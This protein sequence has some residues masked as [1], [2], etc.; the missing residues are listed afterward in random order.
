MN[1]PP[2]SLKFQSKSKAAYIVATA[3]I[4]LF[5]LIQIF[6][7]VFIAPYFASLYQDTFGGRSLPGLTNL[8][9]EH[10]WIFV[11]ISIF[12]IVIAFF[13]MRYRGSALY[14][15]VIL[16]AACFQV[17][18]FVAGLFIPLLTLINSIKNT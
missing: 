1:N 4:A 6:I 13:V 3:I 5:A 11:G 7:A 8:S 17:L 2:S 15:A 10:R 9:L 18:L 14:F 16:F 12:W